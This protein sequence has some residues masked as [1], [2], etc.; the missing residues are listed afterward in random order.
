[1]LHWFSKNTNKLKK[2]RLSEERLIELKRLSA[3][4]SI[5]IKNYA[6]LDTAFTHSSCTD[7]SGVYQEP[8]ERLEFL[9]DSILNASIAYLLYIDNPNLSEG[10]LS[11]LRSSLVDEKTLSEIAFG[12]K[13]LDHINLGKGETLSDPR[14]RQK[15]AADITESVIGVVFLENGFGK[16]LEFVKTI[17]E[18]EIMKRLK[19][20]TRD[21]KTQLQK[22]SVSRF[23]EYPVYRIVRETGPDHNKIFEVSVHVHNE[24]KAAAK[25]RTKKEAEQKAAEQI[26]ESLKIQNKL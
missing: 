5:S 8:Y 21:F 18:P 9:G 2:Q 10:G 3:G 14:A 4:L 1:M 6:L 23:R 20:G 17:L 11:A 26:V 13:L 25:G 19:T 16:A 7:K 22:W 24:Y 15:V 12:L